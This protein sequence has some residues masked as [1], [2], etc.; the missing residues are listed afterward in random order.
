MTHQRISIKLV[1]FF[2]LLALVVSGCVS[3]RKY[4]ET[5]TKQQECQRELEEIRATLQELEAKTK[6]YD[7]NM[8][9]AQRQ[10]SALQSDT[11]VLGRSLR[12][13]RGQ[14]DKINALNE[15]LLQKSSSLRQNTEAENQRMLMELNDLRDKLLAKEDSLLGLQRTLT[16][17]TADVEDREARLQQMREMLEAKDAAIQDLR[18]RVANALLGFKDKGISVEE[19]NG[20]IYVSL[21][22]KL[23]FPSGS[24]KVDEQG[25]KAITDLAKAIENEKDLEIVVEGHT[26][27]DKITSQAIPRTNWELSVLRATQVIEIMLANSAV[28]PRNLMAA[29]RSEYFPVDPNDKAKNRRIE[30]IL[31]PNLDALFEVIEGA[32]ETPA[33]TED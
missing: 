7:V 30:V 11:T 24:T 19:R 23:L 20:K 31:S 3:G 14:Y 16:E 18:S 13:L 22:A 33:E 17:R 32:G 5:V 29:G 15:E 6:D 28:D 26:D 8:G 12:I 27:T 4:Q 2:S 21:E 9:V 25:K 1:G 10:I